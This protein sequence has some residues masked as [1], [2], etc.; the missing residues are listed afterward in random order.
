MNNKF[1]TP[2][3]VLA[4][5]LAIAP[6]LAQETN[7]AQSPTATKGQAESNAM[8]ERMQGMSEDM[9]DEERAAVRERMQGMSEEERAAHRA[10]M[11]ERRENMTDEERAA[12]RERWDGMSE[13]ERAAVRGKM[14]KKSRGKGPGHSAG[15]PEAGTHGPH[16][17]PPAE[18]GTNP[19]S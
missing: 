17:R 16:K 14:H 11:R 2:A 10:A 9:T 18:A 6:A 4:S 5:L 15:S 1:L 19:P 3:V 8:R 12:M 7:E 13:E